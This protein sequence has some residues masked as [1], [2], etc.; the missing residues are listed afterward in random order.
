MFS[1]EAGGATANVDGGKRLSRLAV[2][3][4]RLLGFGYYQAWIYLAVLS[5][6]LF[7]DPDFFSNH[8]QF[9]RQY[10]S[11]SVAV[12][13]FCLIFVSQKLD[14]LSKRHYLLFWWQRLR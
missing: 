2:K 11:L 9:T 1:G 12:C 4:W 8:L 3:P 10:F 13:L 7:T 14:I 5:T 6:V